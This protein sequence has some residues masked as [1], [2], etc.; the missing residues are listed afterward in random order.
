MDRIHVDNNL[1]LCWLDYGLGRKGD[2]M[3]C[4][5][6]DEKDNYMRIK[7]LSICEWCGV[8]FRPF[9]SSPGICCSNSC[10]SAKREWVKF[11]KKNPIGSKVGKLTLKEHLCDKTAKKHRFRA[12]FDCVCGNSTSL[13]LCNC[14]RVFSCGCSVMSSGG[15]S[16]KGS[17]FYGLYVSWASMKS[18]VKKGV[19]K[20]KGITVF[21]KWNDYI[22]F[23]EWSLA[24]GWCKGLVID[25]IDPSDNYQPNNCQWVTRSYNASRIPFTNMVRKVEAYVTQCTDKEYERLLHKLHY[26]RNM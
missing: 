20:D 16:V 4:E 18:R 8:L 1:D 25:R 9:R 5:S 13:P 11:K 24:N 14:G 2:Q 6:C 10:S 15:D 12:V 3:G 26:K 17:E 7:E 22:G 19:Y 23:K 21:T